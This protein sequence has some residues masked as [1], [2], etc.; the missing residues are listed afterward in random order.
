M[1]LE[2]AQFLGVLT[3]TLAIGMAAAATVLA[4]WAWAPRPFNPCAAAVL[5]ASVI[6]VAMGLCSTRR[7][8]VATC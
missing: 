6:L 1:R 8:G 3:Q 5:A 4:A 7:S 2:Q